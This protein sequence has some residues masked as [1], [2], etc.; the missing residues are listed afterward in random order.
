MVSKKLALE[1]IKELYKSNNGLLPYTLYTR[2]K[3][4]AVDVLSFV[5]QYEPKKL[6]SIDDELRI[7]LTEEG[8][9]YALV[10]TSQH[11]YDR[12]D[13]GS[14]YFNEIQEPKMGKYDPYIPDKSFVE[15]YKKGKSG[16]AETSS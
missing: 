13:G 15:K 10:I 7:N 6:I 8:R 1:I 14:E 16:E 11:K 4:N 3:L 12:R 2:F 5:K 9:R